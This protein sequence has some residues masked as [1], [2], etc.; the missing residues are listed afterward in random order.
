MF[1]PLC[2]RLARRGMKG[3]FDE[4]KETWQAGKAAAYPKSKRKSVQVQSGSENFEKS[5]I[6]PFQFE[7]LLCVGLLRLF[8]ASS[9]EVTCS[10]ITS[11]PGVLAE[12]LF[13]FD[14]E[15]LLLESVTRFDNR[16]ALRKEN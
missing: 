3:L 11:N 10:K 16:G 4:A 9:N 7:L 1:L 2:C 13:P 14:V 12:W 6:I 8:D 15:L 5:R